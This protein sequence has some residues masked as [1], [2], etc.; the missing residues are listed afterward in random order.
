MAGD[1]NFAITVAGF[2]GSAGA[3]ILADVKAM[4]HFGVYAQSVCTALTVQNE[5]KFAF[6]GFLPL[7]TYPRTA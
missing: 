1:M 2:D 5:R 3:G 4:A 6:P 7:G